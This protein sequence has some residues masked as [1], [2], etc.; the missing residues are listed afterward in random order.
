[1]V[2]IDPEGGVVLPHSLR[3]ANSLAR[4]EPFVQDVPVVIHFPRSVPP[5]ETTGRHIF[6]AHML[7]L[8]AAAN[9]QTKALH[10]GA[11]AQQEGVHE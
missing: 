10:G 1:M 11:V 9:P 5:E 3:L 2:A 4:V 8:H 6:L 7:L